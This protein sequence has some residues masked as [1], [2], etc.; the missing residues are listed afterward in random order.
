MWWWV[1][2]NWDHGCNKCHGKKKK[3]MLLILD[4]GLYSSGRHNIRT[5][6]TID[7]MGAMAA[8]MA[9]SRL[10]YRRLISHV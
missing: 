6:D 7:M 8:N 4:R 3:S 10:T 2:G 9:G 5:M 1:W